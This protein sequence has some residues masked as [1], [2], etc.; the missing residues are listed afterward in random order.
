VTAPFTIE[1]FLGVCTR[2]NYAIWHIQIPVYGLGIVA[3]SALQ[4]RTTVAAQLTL[5][6][7]ALMWA[8]NGVGYHLL[9]FS[10]INPLAKG[11]AAFFFL[12]TVIR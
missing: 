8:V 5:S 9:C 4:S 10:E 1:Q 3:V 12:Q 2:Y 7:L 6:I 11:F